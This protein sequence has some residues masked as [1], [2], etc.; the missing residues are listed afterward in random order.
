LLRKEGRLSPIGQD[1][2]N[3]Q[4]ASL[5]TEQ[6]KGIEIIREGMASI[7]SNDE[8]ILKFNSRDQKRVHDKMPSAGFSPE[9]GRIEL[10]R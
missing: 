6:T 4:L 7:N 10:A 5:V 8:I 1:R 9:D 3:I 2:G